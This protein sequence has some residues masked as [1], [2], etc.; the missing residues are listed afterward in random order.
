MPTQPFEAQLLL[1]RW[2]RAILTVFLISPHFCTLFHS[3]HILHSII[4]SFPFLAA[5]APSF[6]PGDS[7]P[8]PSP[9]THLS[10]LTSIYNANPRLPIPLV[11]QPNPPPSL[12]PLNPHQN[13]DPPLLP[14]FRLLFQITPYPPE[15]AARPCPSFPSPPARRGGRP[16]AS[17]ATSTR[18]PLT[19][20]ISLFHFPCFCSSSAQQRLGTAMHVA[21]LFLSFP[22]RGG[23]L[24]RAIGRKR[25]M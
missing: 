23:I 19:S 6:S 3:K 13:K 17:A 20:H 22:L 5:C 10:V 11:S 18:Y 2:S 7:Y 21:Y 12:P 16:H 4:S 9:L 14:R 8:P 25:G 24:L 1:D 15:K